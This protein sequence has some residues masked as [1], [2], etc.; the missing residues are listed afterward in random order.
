MYYS[1]MEDSVAKQL[2]LYSYMGI[3]RVCEYCGGPA[4][5]RDHV[6]SK[7]L[8]DIPNPGNQRRV[9]ACVKCNGG[10]SADEEYVACLLEAVIVGSTQPSAIMR[11]KIQR[12][13]M[14]QPKLASRINQSSVIVDEALNWRPENERLTKVIKKLAQ[15][16]TARDLSMPCLGEPDRMFIAPLML[17]SDSER[18][19]FEFEPRD[20][21]WPEIG[22][23]AFVQAV[24]SSVMAE[25]QWKIVQPGRYR[26]ALPPSTTVK[27]KFVLSEYL[28]CEVVWDRPPK[29][30]QFRSLR[31]RSK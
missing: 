8:L 17:M 2:D 14:N 18:A 28:A 12:S 21:L 7:I 26:Y 22:S 30:A 29:R 20:S 3:R 24:M 10:I 16:H 6:P 1:S 11:S 23:R 25:S 9:N 5:T 15:G 4:T 27:V 13:L 31:Y 19:F